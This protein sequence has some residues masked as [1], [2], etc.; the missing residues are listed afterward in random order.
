MKLEKKRIEEEAEMTE[1]RNMERIE[2]PKSPKDG[3]TINLKLFSEHPA[4][5]E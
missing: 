4:Q 1:I 5:L 2:T 3:I